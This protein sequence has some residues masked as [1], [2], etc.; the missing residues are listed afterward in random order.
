MHWMQFDVGPIMLCEQIFYHENIHQYKLFSHLRDSYRVVYNSPQ[1]DIRDLLWSNVPTRILFSEHGRQSS[2]EQQE[3]VGL[4]RP[5]ML[6][7][8]LVVEPGFEH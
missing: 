7:R 2:I 4:C 8:L 6:L 1:E 5:Q 3:E